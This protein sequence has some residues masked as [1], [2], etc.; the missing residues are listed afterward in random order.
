[1]GR[2][3]V[4]RPEP[5]ASAMVAAL[6]ARGVEAEAAP[7]LDIVGVADP[8]ARVRAADAG[9]DGL[10]F[11]SA[12]AARL[13]AADDRRADLLALPV[14]AVGA[15]TAAAARAAGFLS[16]SSSDGDAAALVAA[17]AASGRRRLV[18]VAGHDR[19][20]AVAERLNAAGQHVSIAEIYHA[21]PTRALDAS[22]ANGLAAGR[23]SALVVA[24]AR[25]A[26][27]FAALMSSNGGLDRLAE[28]VLFAISTAAAA[29]LAPYCRRTVVADRPPGDALLDSVL[30]GVPDG[31]DRRRDREP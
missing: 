15:A 3:L 6:A 4:L 9:A 22:L 24:S 10:I 30:A 26:A 18:H 17:L 14:F 8:V 20:G 27:A 28:L 19:T 12:Q 11:T 13:I 2:L 21:E 5:Q 16:V 31:D 25:T 1:M 29:P 7:M 23:F